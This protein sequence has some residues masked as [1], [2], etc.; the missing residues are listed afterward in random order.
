[1]PEPLK[2]K[3]KFLDHISEV[4]EDRMSD[5][6]GDMS[7]QELFNMTVRKRLMLVRDF[8][9]LDEQPQVDQ[10]IGQFSDNYENPPSMMFT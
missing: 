5:M 2:K 10:L 9:R 3:A 1:L 6:V 7:E 8:C 4:S